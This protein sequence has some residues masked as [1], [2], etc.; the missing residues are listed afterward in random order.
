M[1]DLHKPLGYYN[2]FSFFTIFNNNKAQQNLYTECDVVSQ[3][4]SAIPK[5]FGEKSYNC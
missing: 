2:S 3:N 1:R 5:V 4:I